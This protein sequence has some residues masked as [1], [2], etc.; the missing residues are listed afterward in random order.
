MN[1]FFGTVRSFLLE[2]LP[3]QRCF[4]EATVR[5]YDHALNLFVHYLSGRFKW[6]DRPVTKNQTRP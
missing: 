1:D 2:Y 4:S 5:S 6:E 3:N